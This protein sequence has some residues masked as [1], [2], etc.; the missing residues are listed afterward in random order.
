[1]YGFAHSLGGMLFAYAR[2]VPSQAMQDSCQLAVCKSCAN[3]AL[4]KIVASLP[5]S[6]VA[7]V[8]DFVAA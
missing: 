7:S 4:R 1:M 8:I 5:F 3:P 6:F 2:L